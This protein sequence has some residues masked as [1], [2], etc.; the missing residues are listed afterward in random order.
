MSPTWLN[1]KQGQDWT[2][3]IIPEILFVVR[4][5]CFCCIKKWFLNS[6]TFNNVT[7]HPGNSTPHPPL[8]YITVT[9]WMA[10]YI[11]RYSVRRT[12]QSTSPPGG[13]AYSFRYKLYFSLGSIQLQYNYCTKTI[14]SHISTTVCIA[15]CSFI[16][17]N[18]LR[19][20]GENE[21][22][23][24]FEMQQCACCHNTRIISLRTAIGNVNMWK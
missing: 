16:R 1:D 15:R 13:P 19:R 17:L 18:E 14:H 8:R 10:P 6:V 5:G 4:P 7:L 24:N 9:T 3:R 23:Q 2:C 22:A 21:N 12:A 11:L 20:R